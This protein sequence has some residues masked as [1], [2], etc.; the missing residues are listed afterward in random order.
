MTRSLHS[1][2]WPSRAHLR[3]RR[4]P[5][6]FLSIWQLLMTLSGIVAS[7]VSC[8]DAFLINTWSKWL[9]NLSGIEFSS[10]PSVTVSEAGYDVCEMVS[11]MDHSWLPSFLTS[12][13]TI[14]LPQFPRSSLCV[15]RRPGI[16]AYLERLEDF[17]G[18]SK[19]RHDNTFSVSPDLEAEAQPH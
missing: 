3:P 7:P 13:H 2:P 5:V 15:C 16:D 10:F 17:G 18:H 9:W 19:P 6:L 4:R 1:S 11:H 14:C 12:T 8:W